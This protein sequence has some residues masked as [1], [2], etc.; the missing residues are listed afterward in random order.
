MAERLR[1][2][3]AQRQVS[4]DQLAQHVDAALSV[5]RR[6]VAGSIRIRAT[7]M[8]P[9]PRR[10]AR[11][12]RISWPAVRLVG[13]NHVAL[14]VGDVEE[15][16][17]WYGRFFEF[18]LRGRAGAAMAFI[19]IG[20]Q[21]IAMAAGRSQPPDQARHFGLLVDDKEAVRAALRAAGVSVQASG[22]LDFLDPWG[23]HV[24]VVDYREIQFSKAPGVLR[25]MGIGAL[26]KT[27]AAKQELRSKG[28]AD[29]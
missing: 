27:P 21:F 14:E 2:R 3:P 18:E 29:D 25:G 19:D 4:V 17:A 6:A 12:D 23:N 16:L 24:Q 22:S 13:V 11:G 20:D 28:L 7:R 1:A 9:G 10:R 26:E 15:A 5:G 8:A